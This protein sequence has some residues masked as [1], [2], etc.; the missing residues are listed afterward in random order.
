VEVADHYRRQREELSALALSLTPEQL[1][2]TV[3]GCPLWTVHDLLAHLV[4]LPQDV[5]DGNLANAASPDWTAAQVEA[6]R[7]RTVP[8]L[9]EEWSRTGPPFEAGLAERGFL[10]WVFTYD[11]TMHGD[12]LREALELPLGTSDTHQLVL[13]GIIDRAR[14]RA[15]GKGTLT[16]SA[17]GRTWTLGDGEPAATLTVG[18]EGE[19][20]RVIGARRADEL[21]KALDWEGDAEPWLP[22]LPLFRPGR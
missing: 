7:D 3:P 1:V 14:T 15:V 10:G 4:G 13:D 6:R 5:L 17:G 21:V 16:L 19:L 18:D 22:V 9:V 12:D 8:E 20:A 11:V 2:A